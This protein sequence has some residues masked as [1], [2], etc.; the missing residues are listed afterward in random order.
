M[1]LNK[2]PV[3]P[4]AEAA[5]L[6][7]IIRS[8]ERL[9]DVIEIVK[10]SDFHLPKNQL[11]YSQMLNIFNDNKEVDIL[12]LAEYL[13]KSGQYEEAG[14]KEYLLSL[15]ESVPLADNIVHYA[16]IVNRKAFFRN[17]IVKNC[18]KSYT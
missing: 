12:I 2:L 6:G 13:K 17:L 8:P 14:G 7:S 10:I 1:E 5:V 11:I 4:E 9:K 18:N 3:N 16:N 15:F